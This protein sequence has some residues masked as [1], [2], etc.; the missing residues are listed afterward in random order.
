MNKMRL[1]GQQVVDVY[2]GLGRDLPG[3]AKVSAVWFGLHVLASYLLAP[4]TTQMETDMNDPR[5]LLLAVF[6]TLLALLNL[7]AVHVFLL[8]PDAPARWLPP[9]SKLVHYVGVMF[10]VILFAGLG[11]VVFSLPFHIAWGVA[12]QTKGVG[13]EVIIPALPFYLELLPTVFMMGLFSRYLLAA[14][15]LLRDADY[16]FRASVNFT[17]GQVLRLTGVQFFMLLPLLLPIVLWSRLGRYDV[18]GGP[19][20]LLTVFYSLAIMVFLWL[21]ARLMENEYARLVK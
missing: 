13:G 6:F 5:Q 14:P 1:L 16:P 12:M 19:L 15:L 7:Y 21:Y 2:R 9:F 4:A 11:G 3:L 20:L 10:G 17:H 8:E 18:D